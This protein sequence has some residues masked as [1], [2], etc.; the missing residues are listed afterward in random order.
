M[1]LL[2]LFKQVLSLTEFFPQY[3]HIITYFFIQNFRVML[4]R[5]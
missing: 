2:D 4:S 5:F 1:V 3:P